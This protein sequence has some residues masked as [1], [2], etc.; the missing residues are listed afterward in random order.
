MQHFI[1]CEAQDPLIKMN[2]SLSFSKKRCSVSFF[3]SCLDTSLTKI[4]MPNKQKLGEIITNILC[5]FTFPSTFNNGNHSLFL[6]WKQMEETDQVGYLSLLRKRNDSLWNGLRA[7][8]CRRVVI[9]KL[10]LTTGL[11]RSNSIYPRSPFFF[12]P[13]M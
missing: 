7:S 11:G 1:L 9:V 6:L 3:L 10:A 12:P 5:P 2:N 4:D 8:N 13:S